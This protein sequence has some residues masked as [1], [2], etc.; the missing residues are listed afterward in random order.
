MAISSTTAELTFTG[1]NSTSTAYALTGLRF[2]ASSWLEVSTISSSGTVTALTLGTHYTIGG[3]G[4]TGAGT[5]TSTSGNAIPVSSTLRV[6]RA[7]PRTQSL[8]LENGTAPDQPSLEAAFDKLTMISQ[9][10]ANRVASAQA[11]STAADLAALIADF[12]ALL[13]KLRAAGLLATA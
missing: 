11:N 7:T 8:D 9:D 2:D 3:T 4:S 13:A 1:N 10:L 5:L 6:R 12:N